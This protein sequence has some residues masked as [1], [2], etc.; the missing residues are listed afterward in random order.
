MLSIYQHGELTD[1]D[2]IPKNDSLKFETP[3]GKIV[4]GGGGIIPD[5]FVP[6]DTTKASDFFVQAR[7]SNMMIRFCVGFSDKHRAELQ[8]ITDMST[9]EAFFRKFDLAKLFMDYANGQGLRPGPGE[10]KESEHYVLTQIKA[11]IGR[12]TA[13]EDVAF[14]SIIGL[15]ERELQVAK[16]LNF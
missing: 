5:L 4:Y 7:R 13:M 6:I 14:Y 3:G 1:A 15:L 16:N 8:Q 10:W 9:L 2:S 11:Y 12:N